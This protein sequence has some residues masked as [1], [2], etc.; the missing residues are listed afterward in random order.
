MAGSDDLSSPPLHPVG[1]PKKP[2][3]GSTPD[4][5]FLM[6]MRNPA[7]WRGSFCRGSVPV[8]ARPDQLEAFFAVHLDQGGVDRSWETG[9]VQLDRKVVALGL[10]GDLLPGGAQLHVMR[11][12][13]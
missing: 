9:I 2:V 10:L 12:T 4:F 7:L 1:A 11:I 13:A 6:H 5:G 8:G 3:A